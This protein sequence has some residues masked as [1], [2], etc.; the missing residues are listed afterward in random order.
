MAKLANNGWLVSDDGKKKVGWKNPDNSESF[1]SDFAKPF[2]NTPILLIGG[3]HPY[4][5]WWGTDGYNGLAAMYLDNGI[6]PYIAINTDANGITPDGEDM[7]TWDQLYQLQQR[8]VEIVSHGARHIN[9]HLKCNTGVT[10][11]YYGAAATATVQVTSTQILGVTAGAVADFTITKAGSTLADVKAAI[12]AQTGWSCD[13]AAE[14][15]GTESAN[16]FLVVGA[17]SAKSTSLYVAAGGGIVVK[18]TSKTDY[19]ADVFIEGNTVFLFVNGCRKA[20]FDRT[21]ASYDTLSELVAGINAISGFTAQLMDNDN[22]GGVNYL[23]GSEA[24]SSLYTTNSMHVGCMRRQAV[25]NAGLSD[26]YIRKRNMERAIEVA[27]AYG[28]TLKHYAQSGGTFYP[29]HVRSSPHI[30]HRGNVIKSICAPYPIE[31]RNIIDFIG[32]RSYELDEG[33]DTAGQFTAIADAM[34]DSPGTAVCMLVHKVTT[35]AS[36]TDGTVPGSSGYYLKASGSTTQ[37]EAVLWAFIQR[38]KE[39]VDQGKLQTMTFDEL[40]RY[41]GSMPKQGN[42]IFNPKFKNDGTFAEGTNSSKGEAMPGWWFDFDLA[43]YTDVNVDADGVLTVTT[44]STGSDLPLFCQLA[45]EPGKTYEIGFDVDF[46]G[47][48]SGS[49]YLVSLESEQARMPWLQSSD[50]AKISYTYQTSSQPARCFFT[51]PQVKGEPT[52]IVLSDLTQPYNLTGKQYIN[53]NIFGKGAFDVDVSVTAAANSRTAA[54]LAKDIVTDIN[55]ALVANSN[56]GDEYAKVASESSGRVLLKSPF[57]T[58]S[59]GDEIKIVAGTSANATS[60]IFNTLNT[61]RAAPTH[62]DPP[63]ANQFIYR[64]GITFNFIGTIKIWGLYCRE[65]QTNI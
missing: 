44:G 47:Y 32:H 10:I 60:T 31:A 9:Q 2:N 14:L 52:A 43:R 5:Q 25:L 42:K 6:K 56:Y 62:E 45:L 4:E 41:A 26:T 28:V 39:L 61:C 55:N 50:Q 58:N 20:N 18:Y 63:A 36:P 54:A 15:T 13:L 3:D 8:G 53:L 11:S 59:I 46:T 16:N 33:W 19:T 27:A 24:S 49:G 51:V 64:L 65:V 21:S 7:L 35:D 48:S 1:L 22:T 34:A 37:Y 38:V 23:S 17:R 29:E 30:M 40:A 12:E 57:Q